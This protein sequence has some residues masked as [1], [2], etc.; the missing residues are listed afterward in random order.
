MYVLGVWD[1]H[2]AGAALVDDN[3]IIAA[4]NEERLTRRKL[5]VGFPSR[6]IMAC[7]AM[8]NLE[9]ADI[10]VIAATTSDLAKTIT[11]IFPSLKER[12]YLLRRRKVTPRTIKQQKSFKY[13]ITEYGSN[14]MTK[15]VSEHILRNQLNR[16]G[17]NNYKLVIIDHHAAHAAVAFCAPFKEGIAVTLDGVGDGLSG[18]VNVFDKNQSTFERIKSIS[19][20]DSFGIFY[21]H[22]TNLMNMRELEDEGKVMALSNYAY[23]IKENPMSSFF[24]IDG[25][26]IKAKYSVMKMYSELRKILWS[27]SSEQFSYMAQSAL[28]QWVVQ[29]F[30]NIM[31]ETGAKNFAWSGGV[32]SNIK[33]NRKVR[34]LPGMKKWFVYPHMGDGGLALGAA[35][36]LNH[37]LTGSSQFE[38]RDAYLGMSYSD[39]EIENVLKNS[40]LRYEEE[41]DVDKHVA[42]LIAKNQ[43]VFRFDGRMEFGPRALGNRSILSSAIDEGV[44]NELN[45]KIKKRVWYQPFCPSMLEKEAA[46]L[47]EDYDGSPDRLM[48]MGYMTKPKFRDILLSV[49]NVDGSARPQMLVAGEDINPRYEK[50]IAQVKKLTGYGIILNTSL[51]IHGQPMVCSPVD[52]IATMRDAKNKYMSIGNFFIEQ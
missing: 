30:K 46:R 33:A 22:V 18:S 31:Q 3:K 16:L 9:P 52:A 6:S 42:E 1:G 14:S 43:I 8:A 45:L 12:Y 27:S 13:R 20:R 7:L 37:Q 41:K 34:L 11:R 10:G 17:F 2:D 19:S 40:G 38:L 29:Y 35:I 39:E 15:K 21:E 36:M 50:L 4:V 26:N 48:T 47:F 5:E 25:M 28:E 44:K 51:N 24:T 32:A 49:V 23:E